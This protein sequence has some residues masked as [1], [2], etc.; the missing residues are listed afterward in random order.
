LDQK[1][2]GSKNRPSLL[3]FLLPLPMTRLPRPSQLHYVASF[4]ASRDWL[5]DLG[6]QIRPFSC[7]L[8]LFAHAHQ[9]DIPRVFAF[10][11]FSLVNRVFLQKQ[12]ENVAY[13]QLAPPFP[14]SRDR[15]DPRYQTLDQQSNLL[16]SFRPHEF[17]QT[18]IQTLFCLFVWS[19]VTVK[20]PHIATSSQASTRISGLFT[21]LCISSGIAYTLFPH[22]QP[23]ALTLTLTHV[24]A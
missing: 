3:Y 8:E 16:F 24:Q 21:S 6:L 14:A 4:N 23:L 7:F 18:P 12:V 19:L 5:S 17:S 10:A 20:T 9:W 15:T 1:S 13:H 2:G 22:D 11:D